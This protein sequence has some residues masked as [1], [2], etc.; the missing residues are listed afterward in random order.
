MRTLRFTCAVAGVL[1]LGACAREPLATYD[2]SIGNGT[3]TGGNSTGATGDTGGT[4]GSSSGA[5]SGST[6]A[7]SSGGPSDA[8]GASSGATG[9]TGATGDDAAEPCADADLDKVCDAVD[10]CPSKANPDQRDADGDGAGDACDVAC[11]PDAVP[12]SI[13]TTRVSLTNIRL[14]GSGQVLE[15]DHDA[16]LTID[17]SYD[18]SACVSGEFTLFHQLMIGFDDGSSPSCM[19]SL[20][21]APL[22]GSDQ[23]Q[24]KVPSTPG[25]YY[26][27]YDVAQ[28]RSCMTQWP[29]STMPDTAHRIASICVR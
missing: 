16:T 23:L 1:A 13:D 7:G 9:N 10:N 17:L 27:L 2:A 8:G 5:S 18:L 4:G 28:E 29:T 26:V 19:F 25:T 12:A 11:A 14:N 15:V 6:T 24:I 21:C 22:S 3:A 20:V